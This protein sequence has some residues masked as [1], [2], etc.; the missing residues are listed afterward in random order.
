MSGI[1]EKGFAISHEY[2]G[3]KVRKTLKTTTI[4]E[5]VG[6][7]YQ[8]VI[9]SDSSGGYGTVSVAG[10]TFSNAKILSQTYEVKGTYGEH[11][12]TIKIEQDITNT[13]DC[14][15]FCGIDS[16]KLESF[17]DKTITVSRNKSSEVTRSMSVK[18]AN[19]DTLRSLPGS[20]TGS[21]ILDLAVACMISQM[22]AAAAGCDDG[23]DVNRNENID[24]ANCSADISQT[25][26]TNE[27][28]DCDGDGCSKSETTSISHSEDGLLSISISGDF[29]GTKE[30]YN[31]DSNGNKIG[32][33]KSK[34][35][36]AQSCFSGIDLVAKVKQN[37]E[38]SKKKVNCSDSCRALYLNSKSITKCEDK[39]SI[40]W[41][42][43]ASEQ[44]TSSDAD[45]ISKNVRDSWSK[46]GCITTI[47]RSFEYSSASGGSGGGEERKPIMLSGDCPEPSADATTSNDALMDALGALDTNPPPG[48]YGPLS[49][50]ASIS[51]TSGSISGSITFSNDKEFDS[52]DDSVIRKKITTT[53]VCG[54]RKN[55]NEINIPCDNPIKISSAGEPGYTKVCV[56]VDAF[57][58]A[59]IDD[60]TQAL[61]INFP[62]DSTVVEDNISIS[63]SEGSKSGSACVK[64]HTKDDLKG[65]C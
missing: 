16:I 52:D 48:Y 57:P 31:C 42:I 2:E 56:E 54:Q 51:P 12:R 58:C 53:E 9:V 45:G 43:S 63:V 37:Y 18:I 59:T 7:S 40:S 26:I 39:G 13:S 38:E 10:E 35:Q 32:I 36:F 61:D 29:S 1:V 65:D 15:P 24:S 22:D 44:D 60:I 3:S 30:E 21:S 17:S 64:Y 33:K 11:F 62:A 14:T 23:T 55:E 27:E 47:T 50:N 19:D 20:P 6:Q 28:E 8:N 34:F 5:W 49:F 25:Q 41:S 46:D 4:K